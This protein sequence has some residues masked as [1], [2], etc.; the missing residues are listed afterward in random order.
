MIAA[1]ISFS[2]SFPPQHPG[3]AQGEVQGCGPKSARQR[4]LRILRAGQAAPV[5]RR[6]HD[7]AGQGLHYQAQHLLPQTQGLHRS[8]GSALG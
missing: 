2:C 4:E 8:R 1:A 3:D 5:A 7:P 6:Y